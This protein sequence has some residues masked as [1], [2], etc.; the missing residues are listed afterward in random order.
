[1]YDLVEGA[2]KAEEGLVSPEP[3]YDL[4][5]ERDITLAQEVNKCLS[6]EQA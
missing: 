3:G 2:E 5:N 1:M 4:M 6:K